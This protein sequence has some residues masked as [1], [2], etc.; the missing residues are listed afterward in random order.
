MEVFLR[1]DDGTARNDDKDNTTLTDV[2]T[3][4]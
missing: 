1:E 4:K 2:G 3:E